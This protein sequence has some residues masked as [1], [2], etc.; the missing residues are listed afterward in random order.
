MLIDINILNSIEFIN[1]YLL[2]DIF[3]NK[4]EWRGNEMKKI[5]DCSKIFESN[6]RLQILVSLFK[7]NL[8]QKQ[9]VEVCD[10]TSGSIAIHTRR[11]VEEGFITVTKDF[12]DNKP[13]TIYTLTKKGRKELI[14]YIELLNE[15]VL[16][17][18]DKNA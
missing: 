6:I 14:A 8:T 11:L 15:T 3:D 2:P 10:S 7:E 12:Y 5:T 17:K 13:R 4:L 1:S 18:E 9:L 16:K